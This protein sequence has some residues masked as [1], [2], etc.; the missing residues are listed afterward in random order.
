LVR[1][2]HKIKRQS[3]NRF[4]SGVSAPLF[5]LTKQHFDAGHHVKF[6]AY[7]DSLGDLNFIEKPPMVVWTI[8]QIGCWIIG[9]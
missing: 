4:T 2:H 6:R 3:G 9:G 8:R 1:K 5:A 7:F